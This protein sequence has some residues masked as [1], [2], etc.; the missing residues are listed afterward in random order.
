LV[1]LRV[2]TATG[3][4]EGSPLE[5]LDEL[6]ELLD[7]VLELVD[8]V[9]E[10]LDEELD[11]LLVEL[12]ALLL[13]DEVLELELLELPLPPHAASIAASRVMAPVRITPANACCLKEWFIT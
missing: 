10:L 5:L 1:P 13:D 2:G 7:E 6:L 12:D 3:G 4:P 11:E 9:L 8:E